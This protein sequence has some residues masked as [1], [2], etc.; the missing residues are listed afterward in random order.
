MKPIL[1]LVDRTESVTAKIL[2]QYLPKCG[3]RFHTGKVDDIAATFSAFLRKCSE[4]EILFVEITSS[5][6]PGWAFVRQMRE[7]KEGKEVPIIAILTFS[8]NVVGADYE[9]W[10]Q[11]FHLFNTY[12]TKPIIPERI[13]EFLDTLDAGLTDLPTWRGW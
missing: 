13:G 4:Y 3:Y 12:L 10:Q 11:H 6:S 5:D 7:S 9:T 2:E 1:L 8:P